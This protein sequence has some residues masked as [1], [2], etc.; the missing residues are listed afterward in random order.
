MA[1]KEQPHV[2]VLPKPAASRS[3]TQTKTGTHG[4]KFH[5]QV[6]LVSTTGVK[7][8]VKRSYGCMYFCWTGNYLVRLVCCGDGYVFWGMRHPLPTNTHGSVFQYY[9]G[10]AAPMYFGGVTVVGAL[11]GKGGVFFHLYAFKIYP[12]LGAKTVMRCD[13]NQ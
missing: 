1:A 3:A 11:E 6:T 10:S 4:R 9:S 12:N 2:S 7:Q 5:N 8:P 13:S